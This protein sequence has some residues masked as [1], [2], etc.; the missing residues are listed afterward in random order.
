MSRIFHLFLL[1]KNL[2]SC[3]RCNKA[4]THIVTHTYTKETMTHV[5]L[6]A[7]Q[8]LCGHVFQ[9]QQTC[10]LISYSALQHSWWN[11]YCFEVFWLCNSLLV[12]LGE[13]EIVCRVT[14]FCLGGAAGVETGV[15]CLLC[16]AGV[17]GC[18]EGRCF[19]SGALVSA[20][21]GVASTGC[22]RWWGVVSG[23]LFTL[24]NSIER[25]VNT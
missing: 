15:L 8:L 19:W 4:K 7:C 17:T 21:L 12:A 2:S 5:Y 1:L 11:K 9:H 6:N 22:P 3:G 13:E 14:E 25:V 24:T 16:V 10:R 18:D 20:L 23:S